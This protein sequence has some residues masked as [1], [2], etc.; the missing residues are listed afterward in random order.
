MTPDQWILL[1]VL[2]ATLV[3]FIWEKWRF[4]IVAVMCLLTCVLLQ[5][6]PT[7]QAFMG[8]GHPAVITVAC[9]LMMSRCISHSGVLDRIGRHMGWT[10]HSTSLQVFVLSML[11]AFV[12]AFINNVAALALI[13]PLALQQASL[14]KKSPSIFLMPI[15]FASLLGGLITMI[16]TPP[17]III[18]QYRMQA[19][20][21]PFEIFDFAP[22]GIGVALVSIIILSVFAW[23]LI[24]QRR[25][26]IESTTPLFD[27]A[28]YVME[29]SIPELS[30]VVGKNLWQIEELTNNDVIVVA[31]VRNDNLIV[32]P[33]GVMQTKA[34]DILVLEGHPDALKRLI[35]STGM[36]LVGEDMS[37]L[38]LKADDISIIEAVVAPDSTISGETARSLHLRSRFGINLL[39]VSRQ[40]QPIMER[41]H[42]I[43]LRMGD[44]LLLQGEHTA[45]NNALP[46]LGCLP[47]AMRDLAFNKRP[48]QWRGVL[49]FAATII[50][51]ASGIVPPEIAFLGGV[52]AVVLTK[53]MSLKEAYD[54][55]DLSVL[56]LIACMIPVGEAMETTGLTFNI[57]SLIGQFTSDFS[58]L[59]VLM[60]MMLSTTLLT[61][62]MNNSATAI[63][64][65]PIAISLAQQLDVSPDAFLMGVC[66]A[67]SSAFITPIGHQSC[68]L[69]LGPGGYRFKDYFKPGL[70]MEITVILVGAPLIAIVWGF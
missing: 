6:V 28:N 25:S 45:L 52:L 12:S 30:S 46:L 3:L 24:P 63:M 61:D 41:L 14:S 42:R 32:A 18:S 51:A 48:P 22:V 60:L 2:A 68:A 16:G 53:A 59:L 56:V 19:T 58:P 23:R 47:L 62:I 11:T 67:A 1:T 4:D 64:M 27:I 70:V 26:H 20:G 29:A 43:K 44:V 7:K 10:H 40:G 39:G 9:M 54:S 55:I 65:S 8:F 37:R 50:A 13:M 36:Q 21:H 38:P 69:V 57:A 49:I 15:A 33:A 34:N 35:Q 17:N 31:I 5:L 66:I